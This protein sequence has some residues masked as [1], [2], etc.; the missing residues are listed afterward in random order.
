MVDIHTRGWTKQIFDPKTREQCQK[1]MFC[2]FEER[3]NE[4]CDLLTFSKTTCID[5]LKEERFFTAIGNPWELNTRSSSNQMSNGNKNS[6]LK[7]HGPAA[8]AM[9]KAAEVAKRKRDEM[10]GGEAQGQE[11]IDARP[12]KVAKRTARK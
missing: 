11:Q 7:E 4:L 10:E 5:V 8:A 6:I 9:R 2:T 1:T 3:Y 12:K